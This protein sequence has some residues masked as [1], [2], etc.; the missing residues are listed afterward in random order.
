MYENEVTH[1]GFKVAMIYFSVK[2]I[3]YCPEKYRNES[4]RRFFQTVG[5]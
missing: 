1:F 2:T 3:V 5:V 4:I